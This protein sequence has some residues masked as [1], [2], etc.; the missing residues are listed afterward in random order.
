MDT[1]CIFK[2]LTSLV[3]V[4]NI[5]NAVHSATKCRPALFHVS[6]ECML[7]PNRYMLLP[8]GNSV[9]VSEFLQ[10]TALRIHA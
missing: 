8:S 10:I 9:F 5:G 1:P 6:A 3:S 2:R 7:L 4:S